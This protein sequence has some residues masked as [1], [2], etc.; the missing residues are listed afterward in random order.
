MK[1]YSKINVYTEAKNRINRLFDEFD[2]VVVGFSGGKDSTVCLSLTLEI[3]EKRNRLPLK[4]VW[5]DQEAEWQ[6]TAD[7]CEEIFNDKR[8]EP[9]WF[10]MPMKWYN[11]L[12][13]T[14]KYI[15]IWQDGKKHIRERSDISIKENVYLDFGFHELFEKIFKVH[16]PNQKSCYIAGVRTEESPKRMMSLTSALTYKDITW[17]KKLNDKL[18][19]YTFYPI[20]DWSYSDVW[21]YIFDNNIKY[22]KIYDALFSHGVSVHN[23]RISNLHHET[24]IQNLLLIQ[25]IEPTTW[26]KVAERIQGV[27]AIKHLKSDAYKCPNDLPYMFKSWRE[28]A[29]YLADN[30]ADDKEFKDKINK[31]VKS[32]TKYM[33]TNSV[34]V[35][36]YRTLIKTILSQDF[37]FTKLSNFLTN[38]YFNTVKKYVNGKINKDNFAINK[39]YNR[40]INELL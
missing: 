3:A 18:G 34:Y 37:D 15:H 28:Y 35:D 22:N 23:M 17:G 24:A 19:H 25:E 6:G 26:N 29:L 2:N 39:K 31:Y 11:N 38:P 12:S 36:F 10:Q 16:F 33:I 30:L 14:E 32:N 40:Y 1:I 27:N 5:V 13:A 4:V 20:Y 9:M 7:Y 8:I 21:K